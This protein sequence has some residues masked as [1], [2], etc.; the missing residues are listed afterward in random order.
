MKV[1]SLS[2]LHLNQY[3]REVSSEYDAYVLAQL[4]PALLSGCYDPKIYKS[5]DITQE[6][7]PAS[8]YVQHGLKVSPGALIIGFNFPSLFQ[9]TQI[10][11]QITDTGLDHKW[12]SDPIPWI[13]VSNG[14]VDM[15]CLMNAPYPIV[16]PGLLIVE[17]WNV[18]G[19]QFRTQLQ[20]IA[21]EP[22]A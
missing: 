20:L 10:Q 2:P 5:P 3:T 7:I 8:G 18:S 14:R 12:F 13:L 16:E 21:L 1:P 9:G 6:V 19:E 11:I 17:F 15:P 22:K 4:E